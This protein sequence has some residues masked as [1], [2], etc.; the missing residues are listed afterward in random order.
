MCSQPCNPSKSAAVQRIILNT[1]I[2]RGVTRDELQREP[3]F[4]IRYSGDPVNN[5][6]NGETMEPVFVCSGQMGPAPGAHNLTVT[7]IT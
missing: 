5:N 6:A 3:V 2:Y 1:Y 4:D 7:S